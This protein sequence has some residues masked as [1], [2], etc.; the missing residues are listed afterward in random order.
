MRAV[1]QALI[2]AA[3]FVAMVTYLIKDSVLLDKPREWYG[4][5]YVTTCPWCSS[6]WFALAVTAAVWPP[7][8][9]LWWGACW[10][11]ALVAYFALQF[12]AAKAAEA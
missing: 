11:L 9:V 1:F 3:P 2:L 8:I 5:W 6:A 7:N 10:W 12:L 4:R